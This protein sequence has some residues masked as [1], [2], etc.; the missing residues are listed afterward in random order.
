[1]RWPKF[2][3]QFPLIT[4]SKDNRNTSMAGPRDYTTG[5]ER[6]LFA[7]ALMTC[8]HP[9]C[10]TK[11]VEF[12]EGEPVVNVYIAHI[13]GA[14]ARSA[15]YDPAMTDDERRAFSNL[16]LLCKPHHDWVDRLHPERFPPD[17]L[18][19]W[20]K[21]REQDQAADLRALPPLDQEQLAKLVR[22]AVGTL[23]PQRVVSAEIEVGVLGLP[24][25]L[26]TVPA[27]RF[28]QFAKEQAGHGIPV[29]IV[30]ARNQGALPAF[31]DA[32]W[33]FFGPNNGEVRAENFLPGVNER[34]PRRLDCGESALWVTPM[35]VIAKVIFSFGK[36][37]RCVE[38][39]SARVTL[40]SGEKI[41]SREL[42][43][44]DILDI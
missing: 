13:H 19:Q 26:I 2:K 32:Y 28:R 3:V 7:L 21:D 33:L 20:K 11:V 24:G 4:V 15:R 18:R 29:V 23:V 30:R 25:P 41:T 1:M 17:V 31:V 6:G 44:A 34:L 14:N 10:K 9:D 35:E 16:L 27:S 37:G 42:P 39:I 5:T 40:G 8:Y 43:V 36:I 22:S 38:W 12:I